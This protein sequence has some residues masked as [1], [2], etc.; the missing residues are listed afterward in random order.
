[1]QEPISVDN[2]KKYVEV[3]DSWWDL[4]RPPIKNMS[5]PKYE[6]TEILDD[7]SDTPNK[8]IYWFRSKDIDEYYLPAESY[9]QVQFQLLNT[10]PNPSASFATGSLVTTVNNGWAM[11]SN[12]QLS[13]DEQV[14]E[15]KLV[16]MGIGSTVL[17]LAEYSKDYA[18][19]VASNEWWYP[20]T[21]TTPDGLTINPYS[22]TS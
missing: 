5:T 22:L 21:G 10:T 19:S 13:L 16:E 17:N 9:I 15:E 7:T 11:F 3:S 6:Y 1:M 12:A 20:D 4:Y 18:D 2:V 14:V 8:S